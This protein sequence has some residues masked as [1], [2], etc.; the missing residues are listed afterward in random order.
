[1][2]DSRPP[3]QGSYGVDWHRLTAPGLNGWLSVVIC[4]YWW[5]CSVSGYADTSL[6]RDY[7]EA[8]HDTI[9]MM[10]EFIWSKSI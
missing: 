8:V 6:Q 7:E 1:M 4:L 3:E 10:H 9:Y 5:G 2:G